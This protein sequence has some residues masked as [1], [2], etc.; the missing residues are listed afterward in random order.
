MP[1]IYYIISYISSWGQTFT[2]QAPYGLDRGGLPTS[3]LTHQVPAV[4]GVGGDGELQADATFEARRFSLSGTLAS[5]DST[6]MGG[7]VDTLTAALADRKTGKVRVRKV[8]GAMVYSDRFIACRVMGRMVPS[9]SLE[10]ALKWSA[11]F[12]SEGYAWEDWT[13]NDGIELATGAN[14][15]T[16][17]G[18]E[19]TPPL[20]TIQVTT[21]GVLTIV[22]ALGTLAMNL[23]V[24]GLWSIYM[25]DRTIL[26][27][28]SSGNWLS[29]ITA[30]GFF[31]L[32][33]RA[34]NLTLTASAGLVFS[35]ATLV[36]SKR[37][38]VGG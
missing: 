25:G 12:R 19:E 16:V 9:P 32:P 2:F 36:A 20:I 24:V 30:G 1:N 27:P 8:D 11:M 35:S 33:S 29:R 18:T 28:A 23:D 10:S 31:M 13:A 14:V 21:P 4:S 17:G 22:G 7:Y 15:V 37:W 3:D 5:C 34:T 6:L 38:A 26:R